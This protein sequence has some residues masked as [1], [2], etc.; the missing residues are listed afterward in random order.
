ML[1]FSNKSLKQWHHLSTFLPWLHL[2]HIKNTINSNQ[3]SH[4]ELWICKKGGGNQRNDMLH[5]FLVF[6]SCHFCGL[7]W[8]DL[9]L[10]NFLCVKANTELKIIIITRSRPLSKPYLFW[11]VSHP[12][13]FSGSRPLVKHLT[14]TCAA[15]WWCCCRVS[16]WLA[17]LP[18]HCC[19]QSGEPGSC[20]LNTWIC[21]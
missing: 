12:A 13:C 15:I 20:L 11:A 6:I 3:K 14:R 4:Y 9:V 21:W 18:A 19:W 17:A 5:T 7:W 16:R 2:Q 8:H 10:K 1:T